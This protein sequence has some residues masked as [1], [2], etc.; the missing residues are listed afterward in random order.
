MNKL[1]L[2]V[3]VIDKKKYSPLQ[4]RIKEKDKNKLSMI[5]MKL[6]APCGQREPE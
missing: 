2:G 6:V 3:Q 5:K 4:K 1:L